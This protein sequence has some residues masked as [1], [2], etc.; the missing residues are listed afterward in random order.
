MLG[1]LVNGRLIQ[2]SAN[3][4]KKIV[5]TN[6]TDKLLKLVMGYKDL[7]VSPEPEYDMETQYIV[8]VRKNETETELF[9]DW[10]VKDIENEELEQSIIEE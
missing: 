2:P 6:P 5:I 9:L 7:S 10:A 3:E 8:M 4:R 1:K